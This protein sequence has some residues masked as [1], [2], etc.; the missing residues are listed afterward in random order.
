MKPAS[1]VVSY[2]KEHFHK[3]IRYHWVI[4]KSQNSDEM[5]SWGYAPSQEQAE[6]AAQN[7]IK[8]L[9][10]GITKGGRVLPQAKPLSRFQC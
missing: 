9:L 10:S 2:Q 4:C 8:D 6:Q 1:Y 3:G 5:I 7:E